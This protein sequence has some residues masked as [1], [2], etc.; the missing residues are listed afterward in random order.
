MNSF[1]MVG[2][3]FMA[4]LAGAGLFVA[5]VI[6]IASRLSQRRDWIGDFAGLIAVF[7]ALFTAAAFTF[8]I[9]FFV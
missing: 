6:G 1:S 7:G 5:L 3:V 2:A 9:G 8:F 4:V